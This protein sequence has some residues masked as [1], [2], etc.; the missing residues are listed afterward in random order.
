MGARMRAL[1]WSKSPLGPVD[2]WPQSLRST[3]S[4]LL[5]SKAQIVLFWG[6]EFVRLY[7]DAYRPV[8]GAKHPHALGLPGAGRHGKRFGT[9]SFTR[10]SPASPAP[11]RRFGPRIY[12]SRSSATGFRRRPTSTCR[13]IRSGWNRAKSADV[14]IVTETTDRVVGERRLALLKGLAERMPPRARHGTP[15]SWPPRPSPLK[16]QDVLFALTYLG[17]ELQSCT[18]GAREQL[19]VSK[20]ELV[21]ELAIA[22]VEPRRRRLA[23]DRRSQSAAPVRRPIP[24]VPGL[25]ADQLE[26]RSLTRAR[27][28]DRRDNVP[29]PW[30]HSIGRR[31]RSSATSVTNSDAAD[32]SRRTARRWSGGCGDAIAAGASGTPGDG[33]SQCPATPAAREHATGFLAD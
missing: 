26:R 8:F 14:F 3:V 20:P 1:D 32:A 2:T 18:P 24:R 30:R 6:P 17:D 33:A 31:R 21:K 23:T 13:T 5:P 25:V 22:S 29:K 16:P 9:V 11:G 15:V 7:N 10:C 27:H 19:A 4:M 28:E 12:S